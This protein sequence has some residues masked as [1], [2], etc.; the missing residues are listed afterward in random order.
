MTV[1]FRLLGDIE[2]RIDGQSISIGYQQVKCVLAVLLVDANRTVPVDQL[3]DR[4]W[5]DR[6]LPTRPRGAV[7]H[8]MTLLRNAL[9]VAEDVAIVWQRST[10]YQLNVD[11]NTVDMH[12]FRELIGQAHTA[13]DDDR[14]SR[15]LQQA[16]GLWHGDPFAGMDTLWFNSVRAT[17]AQQRHLAQLD[18]IDVQLRRG[19]HT[20]VLA[21]VSEWVAQD[22]LDEH[23]AGQYMLAL[24]RS[25]RQDKALEHYQHTR[26][27]LAEQLGIDPS[28]PLRKLHERILTADPTLAAPAATVTL[29]SARPAIPRQLP[30][31]PRLFTGR[32]HELAML[33]KALNSQ[34][35]S[36]TNVVISAIGG[37]GGI[38]KTW[39]AL[40][41]A[42][43][44][45]DRF[46]DG[47]LFVDL[48]GFDP[49]ER[50]MS[51]A[52]AIRGF[53][54]ALGV[55]PTAVPTELDAQVGLYR[56]LVADKRMLIVL[57]NATDSG[58]IIP[59]LPSSPRCTVL[60]TSRRRLIDLVTAYG[61]A[62]LA[63]EALTEAEA[64]QL[65]ARHLG[66]DRADAAATTVSELLDYCAGLPLAISIAAARSTSHPDF[67]LAALADELREQSSRLDALYA[68]DTNANLRAVLSWSHHALPTEMAN[69]FLL[70]GLA[71]GPDISLPAAAR[72]IALPIARARTILRDLEQSHLI[73]EHRPGRYQMHEL[74]RLYTAEQATQS[75]AWNEQSAALRRLVDFY[76]HTAL[77]GERLIS[78]HRR[79][80]EQLPPP[81]DG[82]PHPLTDQ[83]AALAWFNAEHSCLLASQQLAAKQGSHQ[84]V[85]Q[86]A[87]AMD[88]YHM[89]R[90]LRHDS[91][92]AWQAGMAAADHLGDPA[93]QILAHRHLGETYARLSR[94]ADAMEHLQQALTV[95]EHA[96]DL[97]SQ[98]RTHHSLSWLWE[99]HHDN[100]QA[101]KHAV[102]ALRLYRAH[103]NPM[104]EA[105]ARNA[106]GWLHSHLGDHNRGRAHCSAA[107]ALFRRFHD[108]DGEAKTL[109][110]LGYIALHAGQY[111][112]A[113]T[114][115]EQAVTL[116]RALGNTYQEANALECLGNAQAAVGQH[117][118]AR[119]TRQ[120]A[121]QMYQ[122]QHRAV[123][124]DRIDQLLD[125]SAIP[126]SSSAG[127]RWQTDP[128]RSPP[129]TAGSDR[130]RH[131]GGT[132]TAIES[133]VVHE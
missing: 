68:S 76:T 14:V 5:G 23:L 102:H 1:E 109:D 88:I 79:P 87:W 53:L 113:R 27:C 2:A 95:A 33:T 48:H 112:Q 78:T 49:V 43:E 21:Q 127:R 96:G 128:L 91:L 72:L 98:A 18:L 84:A 61:A 69:V 44:H 19:R 7:Q 126:R 52:T 59:L 129:S 60:I 130:S 6:P 118:Q 120:R 26:K 71:P 40:H 77:V 12:R 70:L 92:V 50:P 104:G 83:A 51:P 89:R 55:A 131:D 80:T 4:V 101:L 81:P 132:R 47:Q 65:L 117:Q 58:Q 90:G 30:A 123:D 115:Y 75:S 107:L 67:P 36:G 62:S 105:D 56:T 114:Y 86:L 133:Q 121:R 99:K 97:S 41:W 13:K 20:A 35:E 28:P 64:R 42:Y 9:A 8:I 32:T 111:E 16:L 103:N 125:T 54:D 31:R 45:L 85:W 25:G 82:D 66:E 38:G 116:L 100:R 34:E 29:A 17:L 94:L 46:S 24:Y 108:R 37:M 110:S 73:Q 39:L 122:T 63:M 10:G 57:D 124:A 106:V 3:V 15:L 11:H 74:L 93:T 119:H 22:P